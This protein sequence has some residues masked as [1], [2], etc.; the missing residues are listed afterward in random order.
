MN[1]ATPAVFRLF[2]S[3]C[4]S[5]TRKSKTGSQGDCAPSLDTR[6]AKAERDQKGWSYIKPGCASYLSKRQRR[7]LFSRPHV[8]TR[9]HAGEQVDPVGD[10]SSGFFGHS[11]SMLGRSLGSGGGNGALPARRSPLYTTSAGDA[12]LKGG[13]TFPVL[14]LPTT[15]PYGSYSHRPDQSACLT[16]RRTSS[17]VSPKTRCEASA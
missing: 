12:V 6:S 16:T 4:T 1:T 13:R 14:M 11:T 8:E 10:L 2:P 15:P 7:P 17:V 3:H 5:L 9:C